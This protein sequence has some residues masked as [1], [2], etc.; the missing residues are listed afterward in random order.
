VPRARALLI[1]IP[2][3]GACVADA[4][5]GAREWLSLGLAGFDREERAG[6]VV[7]D[8]AGYVF[9]GG[10]DLVQHGALSGGLE[11]GTDWARHDVDDPL[12]DASTDPKLDVLRL[13]LGLQVHV[14]LPS[15][16]I[17]VRMAGGILWRDESEVDGGSSGDDQSGDWLLLAL[18]LWYQPGCALEPFLIRYEGDEDGLE[19]TAIGIAARYFVAPRHAWEP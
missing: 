8:A 3:L 1:L 10:L 17:S 13:R 19:E 15:S 9:G 14:R 5:G 16:P 4:P 6:D 18:D 11:I 12:A 7:D 2:L